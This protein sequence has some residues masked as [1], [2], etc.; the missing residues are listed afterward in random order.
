MKP[1]PWEQPEDKNTRIGG[2][3]AE[4]MSSPLKITCSGHAA[5]L[6]SASGENPH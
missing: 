4:H 5:K 3:D 2:K 1:G 6:C